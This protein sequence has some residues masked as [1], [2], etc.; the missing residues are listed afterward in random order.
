MARLTL[1]SSCLPADKSALKVKDIG[2]YVLSQSEWGA[3][4][5]ETGKRGEMS[6]EY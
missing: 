1:Q 3:Q 5:G 2:T 4:S 6:L